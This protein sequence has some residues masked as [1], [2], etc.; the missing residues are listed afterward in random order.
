MKTNR[1]DHICIAVK[2]LDA[3]RK[4]GE[5]VLGKSAPDEAYVH[6]PEKIR[7]ARYRIGEVGF[8]LM[9]S[10]TP[11]GPVLDSVCKQA[12]NGIQDHHS[13]KGQHAAFRRQRDQI[14]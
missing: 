7:V 3:A 13:L 6:A 11:D 12:C 2:D 5:P 8:E 14:C 1:V 10:T 4:N 9:Q